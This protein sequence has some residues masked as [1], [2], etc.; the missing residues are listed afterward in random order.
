M[1]KM[2][3]LNELMLFQLQEIY[4][5]EDQLIDFLPKI[6]S[7][8]TSLLLSDIVEYYLRE[9]QKQF[10][11]LERIF[12][13][14][15]KD[16]EGKKSAVMEC[17]LKEANKFINTHTE[18]E[19]LDTAL[20]T[21]IQHMNHYAVAAYETAITYAKVVGK[22]DMAATLLESVREKKQFD[23]EISNLTEDILY[24]R[25]EKPDTE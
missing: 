6:K 16:P 10:R 24:K 25:S 7:A 22:H 15:N 11:R 14:L 8:M 20:S 1:E 19:V 17:L 18:G 3:N 4:S 2:S 9:L 23:L 13:D 21:S 5:A 12:N